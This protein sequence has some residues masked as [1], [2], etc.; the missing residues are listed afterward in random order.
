MI[1]IIQILSIFFSG[2]I[3]AFIALWLDTFNNPELEIV[4][5]EEVN[6]D[7]N[8]GPERIVPG[9]A[10]FFRLMIKNKDLPWFLPKQ[11]FNRETAER[12]NAVI[13]YK[14]LAISMKGRWS[15]TLEL[16]F[17]DPAD[18]VRLSQFPEPEDI[19]AG[20][21]AIL[22]VFV[23]FE[24]DTE[25]YGWNNEAYFTNWRVPKYRLNPGVYMLETTIT[26]LNAKKK[27]VF[28]VKIGEKIEDCYIKNK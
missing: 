18:L 1:N 8:Y 10:K 13:K 28:E 14:E 25:A 21:S 26:G 2:F 6:S 24:K 22:D 17:A 3:G 12:V 19:L 20:D 4:A 11:L 27:S 16:P 23:K 7:N 5:S 9:R 15:E